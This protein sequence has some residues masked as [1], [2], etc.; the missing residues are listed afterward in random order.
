MQKNLL[1][2]IR[3]RQARL[4]AGLTQDET[5]S[6]LRRK[7]T[8]AAL[9]NYEQGKRTPHAAILYAL[10]KVYNRP[11]TWFSKP[12]TFSMTWHAYRAS[13]SL[14]K[15]RRERIELEVCERLEQ[16]MNIRSLYGAELEAGFPKRR[17]C[18][19]LEEAD[20]LAARLR[21]S[22]K[23]GLDCVES[24]TQC[25]EDQGAVIVHHRPAP[26]EGFDG[27]SATVNEKMPLLVV[28]PDVS[29]D[30][31]RFDLLHEAGHVLMDTSKLQS[32][33]EEEKLV[34][35]FAASFLVPP[36]VLQAELGGHRRNLT[37]SELL[38]L[39]KKY[40][41]SVGAW[42]YSAS[43]H[44]VIHKSLADSL[45]RQRASRGWA[46]NEPAVFQGE[47]T[48]LRLRQMA[49]RAVTEGALPAREVLRV[50]P[51]LEE[52]LVS[53]G[54]VETM[55]IKQ[56]TIGTP[57]TRRENMLLAAERMAGEYKAGGALHDMLEDAVDD[58]LEE[59]ER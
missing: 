24:V 4:L 16:E 42:I 2:A 37:L 59:G 14:S 15:T 20:G 17:E 13:A 18:S 1:L 12:E 32:P 28:N 44:R 57:E 8:K 48:P 39:K 35:R 5:V 25:L 6:R 52:A 26:D 49:L 58:F 51:E 36:E 9:S 38:V 53:E 34:N 56:Y 19:T 54:M 33:K 22:W 31:L 3:L 50:V 30:R 10:A 27:L 21:K 45:W 47:E 43:A 55:G 40:G 11:V 46:K 41:M 7:I 23:M 29:I